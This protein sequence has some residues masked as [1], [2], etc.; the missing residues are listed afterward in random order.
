VERKEALSKSKLRWE[1]D[2][3]LYVKEIEYDHVI[4]IYVAHDDVN[5]IDFA[6]TVI[7]Y[8]TQEMA[9]NFLTGLSD[10][11]TNG[12]TYQ[13]VKLRASHISTYQYIRV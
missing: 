1:E 8:R 7:N 3:E 11:E 12:I 13:T 6:E 9:R 4:R 5:M 10:C 2:T